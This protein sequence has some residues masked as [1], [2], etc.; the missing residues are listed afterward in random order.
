MRTLV[1]LYDPIA[2]EFRLAPGV[3]LGPVL[4]FRI[5]GLGG[6]RHDLPRTRL[7]RVAHL[8][9]ELGWFCPLFL[10]G[11]ILFALIA[12]LADFR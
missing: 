5:R 9:F 10:G 8:M 7:G 3:P 2:E 4:N 1:W 6:Y 11:T 12:W